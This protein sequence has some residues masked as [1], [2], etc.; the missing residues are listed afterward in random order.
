MLI[1]AI[2]IVLIVICA[3]LIMGLFPKPPKGGVH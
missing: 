1:Y 2:R 3:L